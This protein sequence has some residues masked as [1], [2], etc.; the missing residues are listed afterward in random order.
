M[1]FPILDDTP[2]KEIVF[3]ISYDGI[4]DKSCFDDFVNLN[5]VK[6]K[7]ND[8]KPSETNSIQIANGGLK[9]TR[10][11]TGFHLKNDNEVLQ[12][13]MGSISYHYLNN[14]NGFDKMLDSLLKYW[15]A[16][17]RITKDNLSISEISVRYINVI[18]I[19]EDNPASHLVQLY[20]KQ[21]DDRKIFNFQNLVTFSYS[22]YP[23]YIIN[24]VS[25]KPKNEFVLL[26]ISV[27]YKYKVSNK[28]ESLKD[29]FR[30]LQELKNK[31]FFDSIT[32]KALIK[33]MKLK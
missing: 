6:E 31:A 3:S 29:N 16:F 24:V 9:H 10:D 30:P 26:D 23:E 17:D 2:I 15:E 21:S 13:R 7:F 14:Y 25:T 1:P 5:F 20:P 19:D 32:A 18:E 22:K 12:M 4:V 33:Y 8:I 27:N 28:N 11:N